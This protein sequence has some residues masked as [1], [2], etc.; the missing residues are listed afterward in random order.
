MPVIFRLN[1]C[2][3][4]GGVFVTGGVFVG[5]AAGGGGV[6]RLSK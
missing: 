3:C 6:F 5:D 1:D 4:D 2:V